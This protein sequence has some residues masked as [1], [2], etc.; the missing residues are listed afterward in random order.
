MMPLHY[1]LTDGLVFVAAAWGAWHL[2]RAGKP[3]GALGVALFALAAAIG[4]VRVTSGL[5]E[6]LA[7]AHRFASQF[8]GLLGL[9]LLLWQIFETSVGPVSSVFGAVIC[10][11][12]LWLAI[13]IPALGSPI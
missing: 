11:S 6:P 8:G 3:I 5:I 10:I 4:T 2:I 9:L 7:G 12:A 1:A 13:I